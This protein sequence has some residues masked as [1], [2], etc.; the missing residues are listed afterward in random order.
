LYIF[1][2]IASIILFALFV[3]GTNAYENAIESQRESVMR[4]INNIDT[5][6]QFIIIG[7]SVFIAVASFG[8]R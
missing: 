1:G 6:Y 2:Y 3:W 8:F 5:I 7:G 4:K